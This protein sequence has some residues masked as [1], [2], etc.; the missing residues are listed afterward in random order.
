MNVPKIRTLEGIQLITVVPD[1]MLLESCLSCIIEDDDTDNASDIQI[2][3]ESRELA[4][5]LEYALTSKYGNRKELEKQAGKI[6]R[7]CFE[8]KGEL[9]TVYPGNEET[10]P[11]KATFI[12]SIPDGGLYLV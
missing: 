1:D 3:E 2:A 10:P 8:G 12:G 11:E 4:Q 7:E 6:L 5:L 9:V